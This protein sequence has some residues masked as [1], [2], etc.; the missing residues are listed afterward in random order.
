[1]PA[2]SQATPITILLT[3]VTGFLGKVVLEELIRQRVEG[4]FHFDR[5]LLPIRS[6]RGQ[7]AFERFFGKVIKSPCFSRLPSG[8]HNDVKVIPG[9]LMEPNCGVNP[10]SMEELTRK[11]T[12]IIHCAGCVSFDSPMN[13]LLAENMTASLNILQLAQKCHNLKRLVA[14]STA[15]ACHETGHPNNYTLAKCLAEHFIVQKKGVTPLTIV[16]PSI[17]SA[18][19]KY[20]FPGWI[21]SF[22]ALASPISAFALGGLKVLHG[23]PSAILDVVPVDKVAGCL[24]REALSS[25]DS[26]INHETAPTKFVHCVSTIKHGPSTWDIVHDTVMYFSQPEN[27]ILYKPSGWYVGTDD[28]LFCLYKFIFQYL[29]IK[30]AELTALLRLDWDGAAK[31]RK[32]LIR[33]QQIDTHFRYFVENTYDYHCAVEVLPE[34]FDKRAY[35]QT[36]L[37]GMRQNLLLPLLAKMKP[38]EAVVKATVKD[39]CQDQ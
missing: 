10:G 29:P 4:T 14:T 39:S 19:W 12:H 8:W 17:I 20:P 9:D 28:R 6:S 37:E 38:K 25:H 34:D 16:R 5:V 18:S 2:E 35:M 33:L 3:G 27:T 26:N 11:V 36:S 1:M 30:L 22:A 21:D 7:T 15:Y 32:T 13:V 23:E 31:A 24:I